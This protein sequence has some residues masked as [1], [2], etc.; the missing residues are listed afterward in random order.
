MPFIIQKLNLIFL[1]F[2]NYFNT[3]NRNKLTT[4]AARLQSALGCYFLTINVTEPF[5]KKI[6]SNRYEE[7]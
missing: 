3:S 2:I 6:V 1:L 4:A 7:K 5:S